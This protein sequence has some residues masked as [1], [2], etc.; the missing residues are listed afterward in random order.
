MDRHAPYIGVNGHAVVVED[1]NQGLPRRAP[2]VVESLIGQ[3]AGHGSVA[4]QGPPRSSPPRT[5]SWPGPCPGPQRRSWRRGPPQTRHGCS[6]PG[7]GKRARPSNWRR[8]GEELP[9]PGEGLVDIALVAHVEHQPVPGGVVDP[10]DGH[11]QLH[12]PQGWRPD[13]RRCGATLST[14]N[15]RS[16]SH[17]SANSARFS[18]FTSSGDV[19]RSRIK[20]SPLY[21][22][23]EKNVKHPAY[24]LQH[25]RALLNGKGLSHSLS[26]DGQ[27]RHQ[28]RHSQGRPH[29]RQAEGL[30]QPQDNHGGGGS[31]DDGRRCPPTT[32][33][34][35]LET[36]LARRISRSASRAPRHLPGRHGVEGAARPRQS[37]PRQQYQR[38]CP[39]G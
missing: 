1:H 36:W 7:L 19:I 16:S 25:R 39:A 17:S 9:P 23:L 15:R 29:R 33:L 14:R 12:R 28:G 21:L 30:L 31:A 35:K 32:S 37:P 8:G 11:R 20:R 3:A 4:D 22:C 13:A 10:V 5:A 6:H 2:G 26:A 38:Q 18:F 27:P 24:N 34:Q